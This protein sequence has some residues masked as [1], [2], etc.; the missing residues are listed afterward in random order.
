MLIIII[1]VYSIRILV[2]DY[3][4]TQFSSGQAV[5]IFY[6]KNQKQNQNWLTNLAKQQFVTG[7]GRPTVEE[8]EEGVR[9]EGAE[10]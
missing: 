5:T 3:S 6:T 4:P 7:N 1:A 9:N 10:R 8:M 2:G